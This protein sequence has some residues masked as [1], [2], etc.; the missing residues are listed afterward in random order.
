ML[1]YTNYVHLIYTAI[2]YYFFMFL[3][4]VSQLDDIKCSKIVKYYY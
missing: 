2:L 1:I 3:K 4:E